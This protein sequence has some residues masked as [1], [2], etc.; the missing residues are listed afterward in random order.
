M[1]NLLF[2]LLENDLN[3]RKPHI[4]VVYVWKGSWTS[5]AAGVVIIRLAAGKRQWSTGA[6]RR[7]CD[8]SI[9]FRHW[10]L[11]I[12]VAYSTQV[13][14]VLFNK[15][16][17]AAQKTIKSPG[18]ELYILNFPWVWEYSFFGIYTE[19]RDKNTRGRTYQRS[20]IELLCVYL[21]KYKMFVL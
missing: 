6:M 7:Q 16:F 18:V 9:Y 20:H 3:G 12:C 14:S 4:D 5:K 1:Y 19:K 11:Y 13:Q 15:A 21:F 8:F 17:W 10:T 2:W